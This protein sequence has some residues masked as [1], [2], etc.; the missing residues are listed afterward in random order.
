MLSLKRGWLVKGANAMYNRQLEVF[1]AVAERGSVSKAAASLFV[2]P[3]AVS[4]QLTALETRL[5][6]RL[7]DRSTKGAVLTTAGAYLLDQARELMEMAR[8]SVAVAKKIEAGNGVLVVA[9]DL[10][11]HGFM[12]DAVSAYLTG[13]PGRE[14]SYVPSQSGCPLDEVLAGEAD[15]CVYG[16]GDSLR[17]SGLL[18]ETLFADESLCVVSSASELASKSVVTPNDLAGF[19]VYMPLRGYSD[20]SDAIY[21]FASECGLFTTKQRTGL[22]EGYLVQSIV[23]NPKIVAI[24]LRHHVRSFPG[25]VSV[26][27]VDGNTPFIAIAYRES[28]SPAVRVFL[29]YAKKAVPVFGKTGSST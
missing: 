12:N 8:R 11:I 5:G 6:V 1:I 7:F 26:P 20:A 22:D 19:D 25:L 17:S 10:I 13:G 18:Y 21:R 24:R 27:Y 15:L 29:E 23:S 14:V 4:Q 16:V 9:T 2:T 28:A 3:A